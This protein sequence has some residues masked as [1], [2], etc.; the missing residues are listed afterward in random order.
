MY[1]GENVLVISPDSENLSILTAALTNDEPDA[2]LPRHANFQFH[3][4]EVKVLT[5]FVKTSELL[6]TGQTLEEA[7]AI[8]R[9]M[10]AMRVIGTSKFSKTSSDTWFDLWHIAINNN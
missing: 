8:T 3:H 1:S 4:G 6:I 5:P 7:D 2:T 10:K 9:R